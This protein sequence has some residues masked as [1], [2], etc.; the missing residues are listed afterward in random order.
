MS[1]MEILFLPCRGCAAVYVDGAA[2]DEAGGGAGQEDDHVGGF[3]AG[4]DAFDGDAF[5]Y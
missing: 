1:N 3:L 2:G 5:A 4:A